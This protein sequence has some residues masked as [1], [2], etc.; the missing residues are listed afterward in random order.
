MPVINR[1]SVIDRLPLLKETAVHVPSLDGAVIVRGLMLVDRLN[2][3]LKQNDMGII[4]EMLAKCVLGDDHQ[5]I[6][7]MEEWER[8]GAVHDDDAIMLWEKVLE[9]SSLRRPQPAPPE[10]DPANDVIEGQA[11]VVKEAQAQEDEAAK[12]A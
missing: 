8:F 11:L 3:T 2:I 1:A 7:T 5:P 6:F 9:I 12:N 10:P 4:A